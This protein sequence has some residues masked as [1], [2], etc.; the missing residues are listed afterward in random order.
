MR[1]TDGVLLRGRRVEYHAPYGIPGLFRDQRR[2]APDAVAASDG[3]RSL[4]YAELDRLSDEMAATIRRAAGGR[5][6]AVAVRMPRQVGMLTALLGILKAGCHYVPIATDE[7]DSR[8]R[9]MLDVVRPVCCVATPGL[10]PHADGVPVVRVPE[11]AS[12]QTHALPLVGTA[13][14]VYAIFTSGSTGTPK[15]VELGHAALTNRIVWMARR[16][17]ITAGDR[18][19]QKTP[20]TFDVAG[21][22]FWVP[23]V[24]GAR[25]V[26]APPDAHQDPRQIEQVI[27]REGVTACHF[28]P[29]MLDMY[30]RLARV[31]GNTSLRL[32]VCSGEAL[33]AGLAAH[34]VRRC[35]AQLHNLYGPTEAAIDVTHWAVPATIG[36]RDEVPI[37]EPIDNVELCVADAEGVI[38]PEG[39]VGELWIGGVQVATGYVGQPELT[40]R[41]F[42]VVDDRRWYRTGDLARIDDGLVHYLGRL[43]AQIKIRGVRVEPGEV[44]A[45]LRD[46]PA[47]GQ[48]VAVAVT[49]PDGGGAELAVV[50]VPS[51]ATEPGAEREIL[52]YAALRLPPAFVP[53]VLFWVDDIALTPSGKIDRRGIREEVTRRWAA[54]TDPPTDAD[55]LSELWWRVLGTPAAQ[56]RD[57]EGFVNLGGHSLTAARMLAALSDRGYGDVPLSAL[58][59]ENVSLDGLRGLLADRPAADAGGTVGARTDAG[60]PVPGASRDHS[61]LT[62]AQEPLWLFSH[63]LPDASGYNVVGSLRLSVDI[64]DELLRVAVADVVARH[65]AL[66]AGIA[67]VDGVPVARYAD[68]AELTPW[69]VT[70]PAELTDSEI[71]Q[72]VK[73]MASTVIPTEHP[74]LM[75]VG[76]LHGAGDTGCVLAVVLHHVVSDLRTLEIVVNDIAAA[77]AA[78]SAGQVPRWPADAPSFA[79]FAHERAATVGTPRWHQD[80][81]YWE[82]LLRDATVRTVLP[83][84][85]DGPEAPNLVG[86]PIVVDLGHRLT[87]DLDALLARHGYT[88]ATYFLACVAFVLTAWSGEPEVT[89][90]MPLSGRR[91]PVEFD[92]VGHVV[93]TVPLRL[94]TAELLTNP[95]AVL[96]H[97]RDRQVAGIEH[98]TPT[99]QAIIRRLGVQPSLR[100]NPLFQVWLNDLSRMAPAP[101]VAG[102]AAQWIEVALPAALFDVNFYL[103]RGDTYRLELVCRAGRFDDSTAAE[104]MRQVIDTATDL[105][106]ALGTGTPRSRPVPLELPAL[107]A[108]PAGSPK[109]LVA[110]VR[111]V[112]GRY[113]DSVAVL[114]DGVRWT[115]AELMRRVDQVA[116]LVAA[117][118]VGPGDVLELRAGR[119]A[120]LPVALLG[121]WAAGAAVAVVDADEPARVL[122]EHT[123]ILRPKARLELLPADP[124]VDIVAGHPEPGRLDGASHVLFT[125]GTSGR[126]AAVAVP[127]RALSATLRWYV[128]SFDLRPGERIALLGG[129]G[130]DP[131][132]RDCMAPL[133]CGG[134]VIVPPEGVFTAPEALLRMLNEYR[135]TVLNATPALLEMVLAGRPADGA[136]TL[137]GLRLV[138]SGGAAL[139]ARLV[140][141]LRTVTAA[142]VVNAYGTTETPQIASCEEA[143]GYGQPVRGDLPDAAV[144]PVGAGVGGAELMVLR[145]DGS[146]APVGHV[147]EVVVRSPHLAAGYLDDSGRTGRFDSARGTYRTGDRGRW[148]PSGSVVLDGRLDRQISI[149]GHRLDPER[150]EHAAYGYPGVRHALARLR[151][152][153]A[154]P[155]LSLSVTPVPGATGVTAAEL[156]AHLRAFLPRYAIPTEITVGEDL[157][158]DHH[159]KVVDVRPAAPG[160][161]TPDAGTPAAEPVL[162]RLTDLVRETV[163]VALDPAQNF[164]D[165]GL[166]SMAVVRLHAALRQRL[167]VDLPVTAMFEHP[168][169]GALARYLSADNRQR[170]PAAIVHRHGSSSANGDRAE[171]RRQLRQRI[172]GDVGGTDEGTERG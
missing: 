7:P 150:V 36:P 54:A 103:R 148:S 49:P 129:V 55:P 57:D 60:A 128:T 9:V 13:D 86:R 88:A 151:P 58:L 59:S 61:P 50:A 72:F 89:V 71:F 29:S 38:L 14:P 17:G 66:R 145:A 109:D 18:I 10:E 85:L 160:T 161:A 56:R 171:R 27:N 26:F 44:E 101:D 82:D 74:P 170:P 79:D 114:G 117:A 34:F 140:R 84:R 40:A 39:E 130:H 135:V 165:A 115:F 104:L 51:G 99:F 78:R 33:P 81:D 155:V 52:G 42:V 65:D 149:D 156:R 28:V 157:V 4:T 8:M 143:A 24:S 21:W 132:L 67:V 2:R 15:A 98:S 164:F 75:N 62:P 70:V 102:G 48:A 153:G 43:D 11:T 37:G 159:H 111:D 64:D 131:L 123:E 108:A 137:D 46:H 139:T 119:R 47:V 92:L 32:V 20:Y 77:Y 19:L 41:S 127:P 80:L 94:S 87:S 96:S 124:L 141:E 154:G 97:V 69:T 25:C 107:P 138:V 166:T 113:P 147:G 105:A 121:A 146:P 68:R 90:G 125:S 95:E 169:L 63:A 1:T 22:E 134:T 6:G 30:L 53:R 144:L 73:R 31:E 100:D 5:R 133:L 152:S 126:P 142:R 83:F 106:A 118:G 35:P 3:E 76:V 116:T 16:F 172:R 162:R 168:N 93:T 112:A 167:A 12:G 23:L 120:A 158:L 122:A 91:R 110:T 45:V 163:G 136:V